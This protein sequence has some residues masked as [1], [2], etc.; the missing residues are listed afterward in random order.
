[1][2]KECKDCPVVSCLIVVEH[3]EEL[4]PCKECIVKMIC[5]GSVCQEF[6]DLMDDIHNLRDPYYKFD[7]FGGISTLHEPKVRGI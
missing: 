5:C 6:G 7:K 1:M 2:L 3:K 4:C